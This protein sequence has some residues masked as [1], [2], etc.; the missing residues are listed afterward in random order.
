MDTKNVHLYALDISTLLLY[1]YHSVSEHLM[2][3][4]ISICSESMN[5]QGHIKDG[6]AQIRI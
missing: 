2:D 6:L 4:R 5:G 1:S 3:L